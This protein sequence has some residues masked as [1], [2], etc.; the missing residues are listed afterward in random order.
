VIMK[1]LTPP[2]RLFLT[3]ILKIKLIIGHSKYQEIEKD[4]AKRW[5]GYWGEIALANY[6][7]ELTAQPA[8]PLQKVP[9]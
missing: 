9:S 4:L 1:G 2:Q 5:A 8:K 6:I 3:E 7:K